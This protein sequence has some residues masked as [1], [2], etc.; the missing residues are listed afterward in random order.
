[1]KNTNNITSP[2]RKYRITVT[3][4]FIVYIIDDEQVAVLEERDGTGNEYRIA[5]LNCDSIAY[6]GKYRINNK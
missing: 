5:T 4:P 1:M 6:L 2:S 3:E